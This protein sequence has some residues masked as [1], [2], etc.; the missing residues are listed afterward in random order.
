MYCTVCRARESLFVCVCV[1]V[2]KRQCLCTIMC[3]SDWAVLI[4]SGI[5]KTPLTCAIFLEER[6]GQGPVASAARI[7]SL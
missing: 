3:L 7:G 4:H 1:C 5:N 2:R 6:P